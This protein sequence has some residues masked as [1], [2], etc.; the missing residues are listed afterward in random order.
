MTKKKTFVAEIS[1]KTI[2][3]ELIPAKK[4]GRA[5][6]QVGQGRNTR[7]VRLH[8]I[9]FDE[10]KERVDNAT[11][12]L[13]TGS[14]PKEEKKKDAP[15]EL[16]KKEELQNYLNTHDV[17]FNP[18]LGVKKLQALVDEHKANKPSNVP[19]D[20]PVEGTPPLP[21]EGDTGTPPT[22][23]KTE[24]GTGERPPAEK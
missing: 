9:T 2:T 23:E 12:I 20:G 11:A 16:G 5:P 22:T 19:G 18:Q 13:E 3:A 17:E 14:L 10:L 21:T 1:I 7:N 15:K 4:K 8:G 24:G 6:K